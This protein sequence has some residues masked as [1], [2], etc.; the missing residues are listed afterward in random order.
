MIIDNSQSWILHYTQYW[1]LRLMP[2]SW[3]DEENHEL[4]RNLVTSVGWRQLRSWCAPIGV[5]PPD[6]KKLPVPATGPTTAASRP[7]Q[8]DSSKVTII[9]WTM[10]GQEKNW[11]LDNCW[12][13]Q[14]P[15]GQSPL[16]PLDWCLSNLQTSL[17]TSVCKSATH[18]TSIQQ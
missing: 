4:L 2:S 17:Y 15:S 6:N 1:W 11:Q 3:L 10:T 13:R 14:L 12:L 18:Y 16:R 8:A 9:F 5:L 7:L